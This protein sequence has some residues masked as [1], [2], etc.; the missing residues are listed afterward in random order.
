MSSS[1]CTVRDVCPTPSASPPK[2]WGMALRT[3]ASCSRCG[4]TWKAGITR[5]GERGGR[6]FWNECDQ[7][8]LG[9]PGVLRDGPAIC[10]VLP[11]VR[12]NPRYDG[13]FHREL[14]KERPVVPRGI[15]GSA[16]AGA[17]DCG[18]L[19]GRAVDSQASE[20]L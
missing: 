3:R 17:L 15:L 18:G 19:P 5:R 8:P 4:I 16:P 13:P 7:E 14:T 1:P 10:R 9:D 20:S 12:Q 2:P 6:H 11:E